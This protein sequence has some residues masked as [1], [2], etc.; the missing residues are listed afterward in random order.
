ME[1]A[2]L[3]REPAVHRGGSGTHSLDRRALWEL[4]P[5]ATCRDPLRES[6]ME[7]SEWTV[8]R[9]WVSGVVGATRGSGDGAVAR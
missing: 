6:P 4:E 8:A 5:D 9:S 1:A 2:I 7:G 3:D